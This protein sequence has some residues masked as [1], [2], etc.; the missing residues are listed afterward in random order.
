M[1]HNNQAIILLLCAEIFKSLY[2]H[3]NKMKYTLIILAVCFSLLDALAQEKGS[4]YLFPEF[5]DS[6]VYYKDGRVFQVPTNY[7]LFG[8]KFI[9]IDKDNEPKE[10][11]EP[12][13]IV[14]V[15]VGSRTFIPTS[16]SEAAELIQQGTPKILVQYIGDK[17]IKKDLTFGGKTETASVDNY[18]NLIY[19]TGEN[20]KN[21]VLAKIDYQF[22]IEKDKRLKRFSTEK[23]FLKIFPKQKEQI[24][25]YINDN[26]VD[27]DS[28]DQIV[29]LCN[30][31]FSIKDR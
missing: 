30:Y 9:F 8:N 22:Y 15:K 21:A 28:I 3:Y 19:G 4:K 2:S 29:K 31:A 5:T 23:Q 13:M 11:S 25:Q 14:S 26:K 16:G 12:D 6:Y 20:E 17:R 7:D 10:F 27:F 18:S 1:R 24:K